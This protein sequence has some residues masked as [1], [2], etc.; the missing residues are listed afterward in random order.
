MIHEGNGTGNNTDSLVV[1][2]AGHRGYI[3]KIVVNQ[4]SDRG[5][6]FYKIPSFRDLSSEEIHR[7]TPKGRVVLINCA[8]STLGRD[9]DILHD[10]YVDNVRSLE[11]LIL[12]F[13]NRIHS[14]LH[15]STTHLNSPEL[16]NEYTRTKR[17]SEEYLNQ[18]ASKYSFEAVNLRLPTIWS[19]EYLKEESLLNDITSI[20]LEESINLIRFPKAI[21]NIAPEKSIGI[22]V[23]HF[24]KGD[25]EKVG[26]DDLNSWTGDITQL[27]DLLKTREAANSN[28][29]N[30]LKQI[31]KNWRLQKFNP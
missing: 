2:V 8:G 9:Q 27:I 3:G 12:A 29:E 21:V 5:T 26:Y 23:G 14:V 19:N 1:A 15:M 22:Q 16:D 24:L 18:M 11:K 28:T 30:E 17:E 25:R 4:L 7:E 13:T 10:I 31:Y 20:D 6:Q